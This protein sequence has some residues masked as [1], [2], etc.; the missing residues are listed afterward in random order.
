[1]EHTSKPVDV[2]V[3]IKPAEADRRLPVVHGDKNNRLVILN[4]LF[5]HNATID[6][7]ERRRSS[8]IQIMCARQSAYS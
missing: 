3:N 8:D 4:G 5:H 6:T 2:S 1:M 7:V